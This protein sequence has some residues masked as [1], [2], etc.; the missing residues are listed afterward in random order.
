MREKPTTL[1]ELLQAALRSQVELGLGEM[2]IDPARVETLA[3]EAARGA[4]NQREEWVDRMDAAVRRTSPPPVD[5]FGGAGGTGPKAAQF[6]TLAEH[7]AAICECRNCPLGETRTKFVYGVGS[8]QAELMF[9]GEA[10]G[11]DEDLKGEPF[12]GRAGQLLDKILAAM[13]MA[14]AEVYIANVLKCRP[15]DNRDPLPEEMAECL[16]YLKEQIRI[17]RPKVLCALGRIAGQALLE[18]KTPLGQLRKRWHEYEGVPLLVTY[19]PA[20]LL[21][22]PEYKKETWEDMQMVLAKLDELRSR[23]G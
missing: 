1:P 18:T 5:L 6:G 15:P 7:R 23:A 17:I 22:F 13:S 2:I 10:P 4:A 19:H 20:A 14:R 16:P 8:P 12:V 9:V 21:R 11:R 3:A